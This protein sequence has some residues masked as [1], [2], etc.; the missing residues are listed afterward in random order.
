MLAFCD[1]CKGRGG[2]TRETN[3]TGTSMLVFPKL[4]TFATKDD[5]DDHVVRVASGRNRKP[6]AV[7]TFG[8]ADCVNGMLD[9]TM[10]DDTSLIV[11]KSD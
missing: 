6:D 9:E 4:V 7:R 8:S 10:D 5:G 11:L 3:S 2:A 1:D